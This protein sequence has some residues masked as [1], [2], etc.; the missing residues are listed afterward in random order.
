MPE[1]IT[2]VLSADQRTGDVR[3]LWLFLSH[4][5]RGLCDGTGPDRGHDG[6][7]GRVELPPWGQGFSGSG[8][9]GRLGHLHLDLVPASP[10][11]LPVCSVFGPTWS[12]QSNAGLG[13]HLLVTKPTEHRRWRY[14]SLMD[15]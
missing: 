1:G 3:S 8:A 10:C 12:V 15:G 13:V 9:R 6:S 7:R 2:L 5:G 11:C 14:Q 4:T